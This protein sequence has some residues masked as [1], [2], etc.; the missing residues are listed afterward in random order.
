MK[1]ILLIIA[2]CFL[3]SGSAYASSSSIVELKDFKLGMTKKEFKKN[4]K[5]A[6]K[7]Y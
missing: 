3:F 4:W 7:K 5:K 1:K 6:K 2:I